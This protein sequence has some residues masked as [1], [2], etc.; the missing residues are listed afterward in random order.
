ML[1]ALARLLFPILALSAVCGTA[2]AAG[3]PSLVATTINEAA[4]TEKDGA[5]GALVVAIDGL[6]A[7]SFMRS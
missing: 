6:K 3:T 2:G 7:P 1:S 4:S 5:S